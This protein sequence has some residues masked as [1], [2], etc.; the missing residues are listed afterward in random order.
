MCKECEV[1]TIPNLY[2]KGEE[3]KLW[4]KDGVPRVPF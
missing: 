4:V 1:I 3:V 2:I